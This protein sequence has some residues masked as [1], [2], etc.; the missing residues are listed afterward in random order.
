MGMGK[1]Q[2]ITKNANKW[3]VIGEGNNRATK[4]FDTQKEA[5]A[6]GRKIAINQKSELVIHGVDGK[7]R[8][9]DS[10]GNDKLPPRD[11]KM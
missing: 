6:Y 11:T 4:K 10:Y 1:N 5:I 7:I 8:D 2:H 3:Q 9:K